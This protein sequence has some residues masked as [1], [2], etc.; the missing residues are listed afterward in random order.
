M[1]IKIFKRSVFINLLSFL[2]VII[3]TQVTD[4]NSLANRYVDHKQDSNI[5]DAIGSKQHVISIYNQLARGLKA[6]PAGDAG[7]AK[8]TGLKLMDNGFISLNTLMRVTL[9]TIL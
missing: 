1:L 6:N 3:P 5:A 7:L 9:P 4:A 2:A 8:D